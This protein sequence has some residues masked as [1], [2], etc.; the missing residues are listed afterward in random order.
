M[1]QLFEHL[2]SSWVRYSDYEWQTA[3]DGHEYL[4][5]TADAKP[6]PFDPLKEA[7]QLL[8]DAMDIGLQ[9]YRKAP[10]ETLKNAICSFACKYGLLGLMTA[11]PTTV[12]FQTGVSVEES[13]HP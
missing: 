3:T 11:L 10:K 4:L 8:L 2:S 6:K 7:D 12:H 1:N 5:P 9:C 13:V